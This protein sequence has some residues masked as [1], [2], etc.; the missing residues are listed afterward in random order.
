MIALRFSRSVPR[1]AASR[2]AGRAAAGL[3]GHVTPLRVA[4]YDDPVPPSD[5][6]VHV[7]PR[8]AGIC[9]SDLAM[10]AGVVMDVRT[11]MTNRGKMAFV[12][13]DDGTQVREVSVSPAPVTRAVAGALS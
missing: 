7:A 4:H 5:E 9:G 6:W 8:L 10:L 12:V 1:Y 11:K 13:L 3:V 2:L